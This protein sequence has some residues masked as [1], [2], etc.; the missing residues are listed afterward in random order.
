LKKADAYDD[1]FFSFVTLKQDMPSKRVYHVG[2]Q[3]KDSNV[4]TAEKPFLTI[5]R[6]AGAA[7]PGDKVVVREGVYFETIAPHRSGLPGHPI[8]FEAARDERVV[9]DGKRETIPHCVNLVDRS[10]VVI[11]GFFLAGQSE[12]AA[13]AGSGGQIHVIRSSHILIER[14]VF[15]GR[16]NYVTSVY[17]GWSDNITIHNN[18]FVSH[19]ASII[20][21][22][23]G[24]PLTITRNSFLGSTLA[25]LYGPRNKKMILRGNLFGEHLFPKKKYQYKLKLVGAVELDHN[26]HY[27]EPTND[28]R[29]IIDFTPMPTDL[30]KVTSLPEHQPPPVKRYGIKGTLKEWQQQT[31]QSRHSMI[32]DPKW[33]NPDI[34]KNIRSRPRGWPSRFFDYKPFTRADVRLAEDS[35]CKGAGENGS[36]IGADY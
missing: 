15:D 16:M 1:S 8:T 27:F 26:C 30:E 34:I 21:N 19:H 6:A 36:D 28:E 10:H 31:G 3:G 32:A 18:I 24:D 29:R 4:G 13:V 35:P 12:F 23:C 14:C 2:K 22:D 17:T 25:K 5:R 33:V 9:L 20:A 11:R 7:L